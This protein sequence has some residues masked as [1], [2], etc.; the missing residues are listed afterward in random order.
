M[1][2]RRSSAGVDSPNSFSITSN[3]QSSPRW[4]QNTC[5]TSKGVAPKPSATLDTSADATNRNT[6]LG[7][8]KRRISQGQAIRSIFGRDRVT[9]TER[10]CASLSGILPA[11]IVGSD[12]SFHANIPPCNVSAA[13]PPCR[14]IAAVPSLS[15]CPLEQI[16]TTERPE[17]LGPQLSIC[18]CDLRTDPGIRR[19]S[20]ANSSSVRTSTSAGAFAVPISRESLSGEIDA[21]VDMVRPLALQ[22]AIL[23]QVASRREI[24]VPSTCINERPSALSTALRRISRTLPRSRL[25]SGAQLPCKAR[26]H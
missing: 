6:A 14:N 10:P 15:F 3:V 26:D 5:S 13:M 12:A 17:R 24:A 11:A 18:R 9:Q 19:G 8:T 20:A 2:A 4:L 7:S 23:G 22:A 1:T 21:N 25:L 16:T